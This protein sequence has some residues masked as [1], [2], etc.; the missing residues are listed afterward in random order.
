[1]FKWSKYYL[2]WMLIWIMSSQVLAQDLG[3]L[4]LSPYSGVQGVSAQP[5]FL[6]DLAFKW[7]VNIIG[8][9]ANLLIKDLI[10]QSSI[11]NTFWNFIN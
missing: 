2:S 6:G 10:P 7:D 1:M 3:G 4:A 11:S 9:S 5:A 8:A